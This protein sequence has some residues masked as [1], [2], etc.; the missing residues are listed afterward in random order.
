MRMA[1]GAYSVLLL[2]EER[3]EGLDSAVG[4]SAGIDGLGLTVDDY[5]IRDATDAELL[6][7]RV[8]E[9]EGDPCL[10]GGLERIDIYA[11]PSG[12]R[13]RFERDIG[14]DSR[15]G[16]ARRP[17]ELAQFGDIIAVWLKRGLAEIKEGG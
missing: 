15:G 3:A 1:M 17:G 12:H 8:G 11:M 6:N 5:K 4:V 7:L 9:S 14:D 2:G 10:H 13:I 16:I